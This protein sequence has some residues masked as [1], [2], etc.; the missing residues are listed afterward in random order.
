MNVRII[1]KQQGLSVLALSAMSGVPRRTLEDIEQ[2]GDCMVSNAV[3]LANALNVTLDELC[4]PL[5]ASDPRI[6]WH[7]DEKM[8]E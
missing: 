6:V 5:G 7:E 4:K 3:K 1:R 2:R 8:A